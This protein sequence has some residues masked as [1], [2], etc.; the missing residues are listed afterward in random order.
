M[1]LVRGN[2]VPEIVRKDGD[3]AGF[4][5]EGLQCVSTV[6]IDYEALLKLKRVDLT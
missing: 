6:G 5:L 4:D 2:G 3:L 1:A